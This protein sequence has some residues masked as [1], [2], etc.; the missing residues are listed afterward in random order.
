MVLA[1]HEQEHYKSAGNSAKSNMAAIE[2]RNKIFLLYFTFNATGAF[3]A[4][5]E[6][7]LDDEVSTE[8]RFCSKDVYF[9]AKN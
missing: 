5:T 6:A 4:D 9:G 1:T 8:V 2:I 7:K 3:L